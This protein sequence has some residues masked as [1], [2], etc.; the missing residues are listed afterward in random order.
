MNISEI[1]LFM[2]IG[3]ITPRI[4]IFITNP[5]LSLWIHSLGVKPDDDDKD[6]LFATNIMLLIGLIIL[7]CYFIR[8]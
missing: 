4:F 7:I 1:L 8:L 6:L 2:A 5:L 3:L